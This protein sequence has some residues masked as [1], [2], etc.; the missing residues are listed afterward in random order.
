MVNLVENWP[1]EGSLTTLSLF[2]SPLPPLVTLCNHPENEEDK[3]D[4]S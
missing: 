2:H 1:A 4:E 3:E